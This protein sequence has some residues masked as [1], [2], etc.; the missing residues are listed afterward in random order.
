MAQRSLRVTGGTA[1][2]IPLVEPRGVRLRPTS[3]LV[4]EA[5]FNILGDLV[6]DAT[7]LDLYAGTGALGIE[8]LSRGADRATFIEAH[9]AACE[10][11]LKSLARTG[12]AAQGSVLR[13]RLPSALGSLGE[14]FDLVLLDPP[15]DAEE[16]GEVLVALEARLAPGGRVVYEH[17]SR[18]NP[19]QRPTGLKLD[20]RRVYGDTAL[21]IYLAGETE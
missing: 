9:P 3:A 12:L 11:I 6:T 13:G 2:G 21:A 5:I 15:Y 17:G 14:R 8:A 16:A 7:V 10:A 18:Y 1:R 4:R 20:E 19:P